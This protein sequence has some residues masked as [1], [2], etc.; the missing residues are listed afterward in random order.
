MI[1]INR[2]SP[3]ASAKGLEM[4]WLPLLGRFR[5]F[6]WNIAIENIRLNQLI[7]QY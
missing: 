7:L 5:T 6:N 4:S 3:S 1:T 2:K